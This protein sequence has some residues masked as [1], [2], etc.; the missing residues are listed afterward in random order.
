MIYCTPPLPCYVPPGE[1]FYIKVNGL[2][3]FAKGSNMVPLRVLH[4]NMTRGM[5]AD[6]IQH[7]LCAN[8]NMIRVWG[9]GHYQVRRCLGCL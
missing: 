3:I 5:I 9:G 7:A 4:S 2:P 6:V 8:M 1:T